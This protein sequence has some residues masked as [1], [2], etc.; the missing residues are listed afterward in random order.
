MLRLIKRKSKFSAPC[1]VYFFAVRA[2][3]GTRTPQLYAECTYGGTRVGPLESHSEHALRKLLA[4]LS[5]T[6]GCGRPTHARRFT[7]GERLPS[8]PRPRSRPR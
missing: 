8:P 5:R 4:T 3:D 1:V 2:R 7:E 6:C